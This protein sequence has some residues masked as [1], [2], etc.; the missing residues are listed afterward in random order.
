MRR[1]ARRWHSM[2]LLLS[3]EYSVYII[4]YIIKQ[5]RFQ[6]GYC[7]KSPPKYIQNRQSFLYVDSPLP[8]KHHEHLRNS[9]LKCCYLFIN[10]TNSGGTCSF[11]LAVLTIDIQRVSLFCHF[12]SQLNFFTFDCCH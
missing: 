5:F 10:Q 12:Y 11:R 6:W 7:S 9:I 1:T 8:G 4:E 3:S 2:V